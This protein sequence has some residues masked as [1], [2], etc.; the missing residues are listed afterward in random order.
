MLAENLRLC[1]LRDAKESREVGTL[2]QSVWI[3]GGAQATFCS[4]DMEYVRNFGRPTVQSLAARGSAI[5]RYA[6][7]AVLPKV[8]FIVV[9]RQGEDPYASSVEPPSQVR[10][11]I[12]VLNS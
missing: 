9:R 2:L 4:S 10:L 8:K 3:L 6:S 11:T 1:P 5:N 7:S 12:Q